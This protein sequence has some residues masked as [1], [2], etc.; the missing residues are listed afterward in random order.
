MPLSF[1]AHQ[2]MIGP[3]KLRW[4]DR[5][6]GTALCISAAAPDL[7]YAMGTWMRDL[8]HTTLGVLVFVVPYTLMATWLVRWRAASGVFAALPDLGPLRVRSYRVLGTKV[9]PLRNTF[10]GALIGGGSHVLID[11]FTH[12]GRWGADLLGLNSVVGSVPLRGE[13][14]VARTLGYLGHSLGS[15][16]FVVLL[17]VIARGRHLESWYGADAVERARAVSISAWRRA[18]FWIFTLG[19]TMTFVLLGPSL[20]GRD[21]IFFPIIVLTATV[22]VTGAVIA[23][24]DESSARGPRSS[25]PRNAQADSPG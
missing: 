7:P 6:D 12:S 13:M 8:G 10:V 15:L 22:L 5:V 19:P 11:S 16:A 25:V 9:P 17:L 14:T 3:V 23:P 24:R 2:G 20:I 21:R 4:P 18:A 1:P